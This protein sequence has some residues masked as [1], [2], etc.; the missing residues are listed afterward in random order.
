MKKMFFVVAMAFATSGVFASNQ[1]VERN[2]DPSK[3]K[4]M[5]SSPN[6]TITCTKTKKSPD[7]SEVS[8][9]VTCNDRS[10]SCTMDAACKAA[11][12]ALEN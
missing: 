3:L 8:V 6:K 1:P 9:T 5:E 4:K 12:L 7:G 10:S 2:F 11:S